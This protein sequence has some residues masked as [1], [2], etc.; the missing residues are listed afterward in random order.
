VHQ[1]PG[2][3]ADEYRSALRCLPAGVSIVTLD[4]GDGPVGFTATSLTSASLTP[5]LVTFNVAH[6]SSSIGALRA[7]TTLVVHIL[8]DHQADLAARFAQT[9]AARFADETLWT[10][11]ESGDPVIHGVPL[12][13]HA[14]VDRLVEVGDHTLVVA[15][16]DE[17]FAGQTA[18][19]TADSSG[20]E[21]LLYLAGRYH[22]P[23][24]I[25]N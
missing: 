12:R 8:G 18:P 11:A 2:I 16:V 7:A 25:G 6:S 21:P 13:L 9:A 19:A 24:S 20:F 10:R 1:S 3:S 23:V 15:Q 4:P 5:P 22:R 14:A 17:I